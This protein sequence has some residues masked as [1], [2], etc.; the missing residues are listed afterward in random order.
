[1]PETPMTKF[2][3]NASSPDPALRRKAARGLEIFLT[4]PEGKEPANRETAFGILSDLAADLDRGVR[5]LAGHA[6]VRGGFITPG[7][8]VLF[9]TYAD[10]GLEPAAGQLEW[11]LSGIVFK[12]AVNRVNAGTEKEQLDGIRTFRKIAQFDRNYSLSASVLKNMIINSPSP[13][14]VQ[15]AMETLVLLARSHDVADDT[16]HVVE[17][18]SD[19][20]AEDGYILNGMFCHEKGFCRKLFACELPEERRRLCKRKITSL[21][22]YTFDIDDEAF[23]ENL[24]S[25]LRVRH[26]L[27]VGRGFDPGSLA[28]LRAAAAEHLRHFDAPG[29]NA[30]KKAAN[31]GKGR[32]AKGRKRKKRAG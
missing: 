26:P 7:Q 12:L 23:F 27:L 19:L 2:A 18:L 10:P 31:C 25:M 24:E 15:A 29:T 5:E 32:K 1:M 17:L 11:D 6:L 9:L 28:A 3:E 30:A 16:R 13:V 20:A 21:L 4:T 14:I 8:F 22:G